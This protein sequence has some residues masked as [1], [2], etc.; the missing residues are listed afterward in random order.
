M[1]ENRDRTHDAK[2]TSG[3]W[4]D[5]DGHR[6]A[7]LKNNSNGGLGAGARHFPGRRVAGAPGGAAKAVLKHGRGPGPHSA[8]GAQ[9][10]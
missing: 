4:K 5:P 8:R 3:W 2:P 10:L 9:H 6:R 7:A 1:A